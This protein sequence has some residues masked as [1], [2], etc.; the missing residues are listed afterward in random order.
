MKKKESKLP[1]QEE[2]ND[3]IQIEVT[4]ELLDDYPELIEE[5][6]K[7]GESVS[8]SSDATLDQEI[9]SSWPISKPKGIN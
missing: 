5:G 7:V 1:V 8:V 2:E 3:P 6:L 9:P 4:Q